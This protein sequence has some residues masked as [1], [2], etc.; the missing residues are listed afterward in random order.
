MKMLAWGTV[1]PDG[2]S[3]EHTGVLLRERDIE[4][5]ARTGALVGKEVKIEHTGDGVGEVISAWQHGNRLDV[6]FK[7]HNNSFESLCAQGFVQSK[8]CPELSLGYSVEMKCSADGQIIPGDKFV[9]EIS[10]VKAGAMSNCNIIGWK[11]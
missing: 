6:V 9:N 5:I 2:Q 10:I 1:W 8:C 3:N 4:S 7:L 11:K